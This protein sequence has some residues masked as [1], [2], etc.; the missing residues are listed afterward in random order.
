[1]EVAVKILSGDPGKIRDSFFIVGTEIKNN[2]LYVKLAIRRLGKAYKAV[3]TEFAKLSKKYNFDFNLIE[4]NN[5]GQFVIEELNTVHHLNVIPVTTT[6]N[7]KSED[8]KRDVTVMDKNENVKWLLNMKSEHRIIFPESGSEDMEE[9][10]RQIS[11]FSEHITEAGSVSYY[12]P[13]TE[14]DDGVMAL[15]INCQKAKQYLRVGN[16]CWFF[17]C[18]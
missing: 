13:G 12:A 2:K 18:R 1:M 15:L 8:K 10:K 11:I 3:C 17:G 14:H 5:T 9:L 7:L 16:S 6:A 4:A